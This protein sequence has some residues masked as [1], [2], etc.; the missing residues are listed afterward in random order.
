ME[1]IIIFPNNSGGV[2]F[3]YPIT[4]CGLSLDEIAAKDVPA[5]K[6]YLFVP[7]DQVPTDH[8]FFDAFECDFSDPDG[9]GIGVEEWIST[10]NRG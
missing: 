4:D 2:C 3:L 8:T 9:Y 7:V 1:S 5:G 10:R 6:P